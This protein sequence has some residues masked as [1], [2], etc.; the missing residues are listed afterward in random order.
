MVGGLGLG[1][2]GW[3]LLLWRKG[4]ERERG[5]YK[6]GRKEESKGGD[7]QRG[8]W[9]GGAAAKIGEERRSARVGEERGLPSIGSRS[10]AQTRSL[11]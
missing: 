8:R 4:G 1:S 11:I 3:W 9:E 2:D 5:D 6:S 10:M 7:G